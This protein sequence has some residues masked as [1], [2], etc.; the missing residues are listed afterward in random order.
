MILIGKKVTLAINEINLRLRKDGN[1]Y[2][3]R[4]AES[5]RNTSCISISQFNL[6]IS[7]YLVKN[8]L[9]LCNRD[10]LRLQLCR[11]IGGYLF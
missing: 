6:K 7:V 8:N 4:W 3:I 1:E 10:I 2:I 11:D 5:R 9:S